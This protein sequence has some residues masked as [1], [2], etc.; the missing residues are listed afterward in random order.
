MSLL[1]SPECSRQKGGHA[2]HDSC[3]R[4]SRTDTQGVV[5]LCFCACHNT[6]VSPAEPPSRERAERMRADWA[7]GLFR[8]KDL[9]RRYRVGIWT[10]NAVVYGNRREV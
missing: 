9:A 4:L 6:E 1:L 8:L 10:V 5:S 2:E 7:S 3:P